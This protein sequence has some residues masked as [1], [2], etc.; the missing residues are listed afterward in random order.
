MVSQFPVPVKMN[1]GE[2]KLLARSVRVVETKVCKR[3]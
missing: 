3:Q 1:D 2:I